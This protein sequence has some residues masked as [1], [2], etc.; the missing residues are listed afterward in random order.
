MISLIKIK[1]KIINFIHSKIISLPPS[2]YGIRN[3]TWSN[4][5]LDVN[6]GVDLSNRELEQ[7]PYKFGKVI[8]KF[9]C[10]NNYLT[11]LKGSP[12]YLA[13]SFICSNNLLTSLEHSPAGKFDYFI[14]RKN[15]IKN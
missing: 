3:Y 5:L 6:G 2:Y 11:S 8:E 13:G 12:K 10:S 9:N 14:C 1:Y 15:K 4:G 7:I